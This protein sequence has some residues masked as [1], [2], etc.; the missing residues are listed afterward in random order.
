ME[1]ELRRAWDVGGAFTTP[2]VV[3]LGN[4]TDTVPEVE[5]LEAIGVVLRP[6]RCCSIRSHR[7]YDEDGV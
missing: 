7:L 1:L 3:V 6:E 2:Y 4:A 5:W